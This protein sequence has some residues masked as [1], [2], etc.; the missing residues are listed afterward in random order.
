[1]PTA[2][3]RRAASCCR[4]SARS[5]RPCRRSASSASTRSCAST[6]SAGRPALGIC[7][8]MQLLFESSSELGGAKGLGLLDGEVAELDAPG[9]KVPHIGWN[10]VSWTNGTPLAEGLVEPGRLL[11]R[12]LVRAPA[13]RTPTT[14]SDGPRTAPSSPASSGAAR[15]SACSSIRRSRA[16][17]GLRSCGTSCASRRDPPARHR[18]PRRQGR[19]AAPGR[20]RPGDGLQRGPARGGARM[21]RGRRALPA[22]DRPGR[23]PRG[24]AAE[25]GPSA[26]GSRPS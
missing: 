7:L 2:S 19:A 12:A 3:A 21:G 8:G 9:L 25:P 10:E 13:R 6:S 23:R 4:A 17:T 11:P 22:R 18:H 14:C 5:R 1:M 26:S 15:S 16:P 24:Q 20:L